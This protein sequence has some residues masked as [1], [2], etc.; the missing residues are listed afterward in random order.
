M[1]AERG[2]IPMTDELPRCWRCKKLLAIAVSRPWEID[3]ARCKAKNCSPK[4]DE[5]LAQ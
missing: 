5:N 2:R 4:G 1:L 3:C